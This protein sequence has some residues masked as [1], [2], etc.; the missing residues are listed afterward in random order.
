MEVDF[1]YILVKLPNW[2]WYKKYRGFGGIYPFVFYKSL[3]QPVQQGVIIH[4]LEHLKQFRKQPFTFHFRYIYYLIKF[5]Y[6][7]NPYE[8]SARKIQSNFL[9]EYRKQSAIIIK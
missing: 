7:K 5:G 8:I 1:F 6:K 2:C 4:E 9:K 3:K